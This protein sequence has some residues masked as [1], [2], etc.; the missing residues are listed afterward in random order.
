M[1]ASC[2]QSQ[3]VSPSFVTGCSVPP[4]PPKKSFG[5]QSLRSFP[6]AHHGFPLP[7]RPK[8]LPHQTPRKRF[9]PRGKPH[10]LARYLPRS[11][12]CRLQRPQLERLRAVCRECSTAPLYQPGANLAQQHSTPTVPIGC[13]YAKSGQFYSI[14]SALAGSIDAARRAGMRPAMLAAATSTTMA[15]ARMEASMRVMS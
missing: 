13:A 9:T 7:T 1:N 5:L 3:S 12:E 14:R 8:S 4:K 11:P 10:I 6:A 2:H 15:P